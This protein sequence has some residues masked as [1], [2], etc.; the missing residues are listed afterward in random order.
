MWFASVIDGRREGRAGGKEIRGRERRDV[1][2]EWR[3]RRERGRR[4]E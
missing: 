4:D 2:G 1:R 3:R